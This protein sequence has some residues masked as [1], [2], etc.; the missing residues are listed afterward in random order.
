MALKSDIF[1]TKCS[2]ESK[3]DVKYGKENNLPN[4]W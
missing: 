4:F 1:R 3:V 2:F